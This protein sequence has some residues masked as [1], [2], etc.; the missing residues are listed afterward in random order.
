MYDKLSSA[1]IEQESIDEVIDSRE[2][3][4]IFSSN[5]DL[6]KNYALSTGDTYAIEL[7]QNFIDNKKFNFPINKHIEIFILKNQKNI[8]KII[9]YIIFRYK[10]YLAG[11]DKINL[12]YPPYLLIEPVSTCNLRCPFC[13][14]SDKSFTKK[15]FMGVIDFEF[16]KNIVDQANE[17]GT[18]AV[19]IASRGEPT[20]HKKYAQMLEYLNKKNNIFEIK[21]NTNGTY[22]NEEICHA[23]FKN[24]VTQVVV[25]S[26][27]YIKEDYERLRLGSNFE[28]VVKNVDML[29]NIREEHYPD[30][31][32][33]IRISGIDNER[34]LNRKKFKEFWIKR[35][36]HVTA[37]FPLE[38]W[39]TYENNVLPNIKD[40]CENLWDRMYVWFDGK[41]NPCDAD[42]KSYLSYGSAKEYSLKELWNNKI[43]SNIRNNH[44]NNKRNEL[45]PCD[46]CGVT[47]R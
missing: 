36:D 44:L 18:G 12:G 41:V 2:I 37:G 23:I 15:P 33:E 29:F 1:E 26:D 19:T 21:T 8:N 25:S 38:R 32:T 22:L 34:N 11:S 9:K 42:Y 5:L 39:N 28:K 16:F 30:S 14:Q 17:I 20:M 31:I 45:N 6:F 40:P 43:N 10:F 13:F 35:S 47:F 24:N 7:V 46:R 27:H 3:H 4:S